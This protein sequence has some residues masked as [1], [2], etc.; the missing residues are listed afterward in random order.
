MYD[1]CQW[2]VSVAI[3][4]TDALYLVRMFIEHVLLKF[5]LCLMVVIDDRNE[6]H[7]VLESMCN[8][9]DIKFHIVAKFNHKVVGVELF[10]KFLNHAK[11]VSTEAR[12]S[13]EPNVEVAMET[14]HAWNAIPLDGTDIIRSVTAIGRT[15]RFS[16]DIDLVNIPQF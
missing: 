2:I 6:F 15:L 11:K 8:V 1:M 16:L 7:G 5:G 3:T 10:H 12:G 9:L 4:G 13:S 14:P